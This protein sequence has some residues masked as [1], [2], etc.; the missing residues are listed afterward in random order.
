MNIITDILRAKT[1][2]SP[3]VKGNAAASFDVKGKSTIMSSPNIGKTL[4]I[5]M[6]TT[7]EENLESNTCTIV[8]GAP[9]HELPE[10]GV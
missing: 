10:E 9:S 2:M 3:N 4:N 8:R 5:G 7:V 1:A 6:L